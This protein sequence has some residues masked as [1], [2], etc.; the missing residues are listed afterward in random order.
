[1]NSQ[2]CQGAPRGVAALVLPVVERLHAAVVDENE[3]I[4]QRRPVD[5]EA[6]NLRKSQGLLELNRLASLLGD[7][8]GNPQVRDALA[9]L[10]AALDENQRLLR[11]QLG[12]ARK[13]STLIAHAIH[14]GQSDGTYSAQSWRDWQ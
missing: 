6:C 1:V 14:E 4:R 7:A 10:H 11:V 2:P 13:I 9:S 12:A 3:G 5:Y 8:R